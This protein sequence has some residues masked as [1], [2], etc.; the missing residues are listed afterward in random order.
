MAAGPIFNA[1]ADLARINQRGNLE[2]IVSISGVA[3]ASVVTSLKANKALLN[4]SADNVRLKL[5]YTNATDFETAVTALAAS[6][7]GS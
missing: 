5:D 4:M 1:L 6:W 7:N 2:R 3:I